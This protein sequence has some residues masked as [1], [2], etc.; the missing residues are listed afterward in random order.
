MILMSI[1]YCLSPFPLLLQNTCNWLIY[2]EKKG[3]LA[4]SSRGPRVWYQLLSFWWGP[5]SR[6]YYMVGLYARVASGHVL[7]SCACE[8]NW[9]EVSGWLMITHFQGNQFSQWDLRVEPPWPNCIL[10]ILPPLSITSGTQLPAFEPLRDK[11]SKHGIYLGY[12]E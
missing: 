11:L 5:Y 7:K 4:Y 12:C 10:R 1:P 6:W 9:E 8:R 2:K 3:Y